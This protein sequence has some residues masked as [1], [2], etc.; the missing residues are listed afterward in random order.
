MC[1]Q[2]VTSPTILMFLRAESVA[3]KMSHASTALTMATATNEN[4]YRSICFRRSKSSDGSQDGLS[5][6]RE[7]FDVLNLHPATL[8]YSRRTTT[9]SRFWSKDGT[10]LSAWIFARKAFLCNG[11]QSADHLQA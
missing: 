2:L 9:E 8:Q 6:K 10:Q 3:C 11:S 5:L 1:P 7:D 4:P